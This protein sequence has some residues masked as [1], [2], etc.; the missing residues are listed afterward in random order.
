MI[1]EISKELMKRMGDVAFM[2][3]LED[4][5]TYFFEEAWCPVC[6]KNI[7]RMDGL[8]AYR[9]LDE[10]YSVLL[11]PNC[12]LEEQIEAIDD[13]DRVDDEGV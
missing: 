9:K 8:K 12:P 11:C 7:D 13:L 5:F 2:A 3:W 1:D 6:D 4:T 10:D